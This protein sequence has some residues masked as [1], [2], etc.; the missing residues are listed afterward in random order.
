MCPIAQ[1]RLHDPQRLADEI[2]PGEAA[3][4]DDVVVGFEDAVRQPVIAY[5]LPDFLDRLELIANLRLLAAGKQA[6][7][8]STALIGMMTSWGKSDD[9]IRADYKISGLAISAIYH[10]VLIPSKR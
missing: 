5:E 2:A 1:A 10:H 9:V 8:P 4:V 7:Q 6:S 3:V